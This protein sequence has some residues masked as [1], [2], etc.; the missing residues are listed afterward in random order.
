MGHLAPQ[1][2]WPQGESLQGEKG[3]LKSLVSYSTLGVEG[4]YKK[5]KDKHGDVCNRKILAVHTI[6]RSRGSDSQPN[7]RRGCVQEEIHS[8]RSFYQH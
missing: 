1:S 7:G 2:L 6:E 5:D 3:H 8:D 4:A